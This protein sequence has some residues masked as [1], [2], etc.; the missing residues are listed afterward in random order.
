MGSK[1]HKRQL[2]P[3]IEP[4]VKVYDLI[5]C[6]PYLI[7]NSTLWGVRL[8]Y[9]KS[10]GSVPNVLKGMWTNEKDVWIAIENYLKSRGRM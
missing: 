10:A 1:P 6:E 8:K 3:R 4:E 7:P 5:H 9:Q 2:T